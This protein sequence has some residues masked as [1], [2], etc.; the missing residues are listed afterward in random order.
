MIAH[1]TPSN[2]QHQFGARYR[3]LMERYQHVVRFGLQGHTHTEYFEVTKSMS[4]PGK[5]ILLNTIGGSVTTYTNKNPSFMTI[6]FD[7]LTMLPLNMYTYTFDLEKANEPG[8]S[9]EWFRQHDYLSEYGLKDL[10]PSSMKDLSD[11]FLTDSD[12]ARQFMWNEFRQ[13]GTKPESVN[14]LKLHCETGTSEM[15]ELHECMVTGGSQRS[16]LGLSYDPWTIV[17]LSDALIGNWIDIVE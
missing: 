1:Y 17:G 9:P 5:P 14:Q 7:A 3:A 13:Y 10:S 8:N 16:K 11:R 6:E 4:N 15:H 2:C 12:L